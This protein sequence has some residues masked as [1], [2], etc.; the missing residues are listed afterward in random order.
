MT[1]PRLHAREVADAPARWHAPLRRSRYAHI[2]HVRRWPATAQQNRLFATPSPTDYAEY[3]GSPD[4][5]CHSAAQ[6]MPASQG[7]NAVAGA[8]RASPRRRPVQS[9]GRSYRS[10]GQNKSPHHPY[11]PG[12][13]SPHTALRSPLPSPWYRCSRQAYGRITPPF[14]PQWLHATSARRSSAHT[15]W[16][17]AQRGTPDAPANISAHQNPGNLVRG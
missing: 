1:I 10:S 16:L 5:F 8:P 4:G 9:P 3:S 13:L 11:A 14:Y 6:Q 12:R 7:E 15:G 2:F 17:P